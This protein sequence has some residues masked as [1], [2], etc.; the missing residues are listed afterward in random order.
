M[1]IAIYQ[2]RI[3]YYLGGG[4]IVPF[5]H[6][7]F[8]RCLGHKITIVTTRAPF[9]QESEYFKHFKKINKNICIDYLDLPVA[10]KRIYKIPAG[11]NWQRWNA[12]SITVA[13]LAKCYFS[14]H[15][16]DLIT[17]Y[18][19]LDMRAVPQL[20]KSALHLLGYPQRINKFYRAALLVPDI[21]LSVSKYVKSRWLKMVNLKNIYVAE[22]GVRSDYFRPLRKAKKYDIVFVGRLIKI[23]GVDYLIRAVNILKK[24]GINLKIAIVGKGPEMDRL[25]ALSKKLWLN[26]S[27]SFLGQRTSDELVELYNSANVSVLPSYDRE[28]ILMTMLESASCGTPV[29]TTTN[30]SMREFIKNGKNGILIKSHDASSLAEAIK[31][32]Y[33]DNK[34]RERFSKNARTEIINNWDWGVKIK[35]VEKIYEKILSDN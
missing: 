34:L 27:V 31:L 23:K 22:N 26:Q 9:I 14:N 3:S 7:V 29:I 25:K 16:F 13:K 11:E 1:N 4:E 8:L 6:A 30:C 35:K 33:N 24:G 17:V 10:L 32:I 5:E 21:I 18:N 28:G 20:Q 12:E 19:V 2:P 15:K